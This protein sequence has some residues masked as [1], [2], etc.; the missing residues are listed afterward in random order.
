MHLIILPG[1]SKEYN[2][3]WLYDSA[4]AYADLFDSVTPIVLDHWETGEES[5]NI[6]NNVQK[7]EEVA[8]SLEGEFIIFAKSVGSIISL[9][10]T[11][12]GKVNPKKCVFVG[13]PWEELEEMI[14]KLN[15]PTLFIQ[16]TDDMFFRHEE[17]KKILEEN[18]VGDYELVEI[19]GNNHAYDNYEK[20]AKLIESFVSS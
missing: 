19:E 18:M 8:N 5:A 6:E 10:A 9:T 17:L 20:I 16:Q 11:T 4:K 3:Q 15:V 2:E 12:Q 14:A 13:S 7:L 1:N